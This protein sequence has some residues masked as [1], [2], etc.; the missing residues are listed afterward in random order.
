MVINEVGKRWRKTEGNVMRK[1]RGAG[2]E[3]TVVNEVGKRWRKTI[4]NVMRKW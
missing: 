3:D 4:G 1:W 2:R